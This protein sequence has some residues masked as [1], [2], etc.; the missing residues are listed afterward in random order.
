MAARFP[1]LHCFTVHS[2]KHRACPTCKRLLTHVVEDRFE[3]LNCI[4]SGPE[5]MAYG[6]WDKTRS[7]N[8]FLR[9]LSAKADKITVEAVA[10]EAIILRDLDGCAGIPK[11]IH[12]GSIRATGGT[13]TAQEYISGVP[14]SR[15]LR[16]GPV[17]RRV[18]LPRLAL[19]PLVE[20]HRAGV[21]HC[22]LS[23]DHI[24]K[25]DDGRIVVVDHCS[26]RKES[27]RS[28]GSGKS[29]YKAPEQC[30]ATN[31]VS[32]A[33]DVF[34]MGVCFYNAMTGTWPFP[35]SCERKPGARW[36]V[37]ARPSTLSRA[38]TSDLD[39]I[40]LKA[41]A[42]S[43]SDRYANAEELM[44]ALSSALGSKTVTDGFAVSFPSRFDLVAKSVAP[45]A[46]IAV[47]SLVTVGKGVVVAVNVM[48]IGLGRW[49][50]KPAKIAMIVSIPLILIAV[51]PAALPHAQTVLSQISSVAALW[52]E[53]RVTSAPEPQLKEES[54][55]HATIL[56]PTTN[57]V[58]L[59]RFHTWP[60]AFVYTN[61]DLVT[62]APNPDSFP[63][64]PGSQ[65]IQLVSKLGQQRWVTVELNP[66]IDYVLRYRFDTE[67]ITL[68]ENSP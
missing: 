68:V 9:I 23:L 30:D 21:V 47:A 18:E 13:Y 57:D 5:R 26:A 34:A 37:P 54:V 60:A 12:A 41:L 67:E 15:V 46:R 4:N 19:E 62:E 10:R 50:W 22:A 39:E 38:I 29:H 7:Q 8:V 25:T 49:G 58:C 14:L 2:P 59:V 64:Q 1:C 20:M 35:S 16:R 3:L 33:T 17:L 45:I 32:S 66:G 43:P 63:L 52:V 11:F 28:G 51:L 31:T 48:R 65:Q 27:S 55:A 61:G 53:Q 40:L 56:P 42:Y 6:A 44:S 36:P 24:R